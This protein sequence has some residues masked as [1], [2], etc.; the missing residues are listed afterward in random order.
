[1]Q[2]GEKKNASKST[3]LQETEQGT[4]QDK[5]PAGQGRVTSIKSTDCAPHPTATMAHSGW[6]AQALTTR[7]LCPMALA[8]R[9]ERNFARTM[10]LLPCARVT[11]P[12]ITRVLLGLPP[13]VTVLLTKRK[14]QKV[15]L[16][17]LLE[18]PWAPTA[19]TQEP[20]G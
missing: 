14:R 15:Q 7:I 6:A 20:H 4:G 2:L 10:P 5:R 9:L 12:Q 19:S 18:L 16:E 8:G 17:G 3:V 11:F 13:G 1:M